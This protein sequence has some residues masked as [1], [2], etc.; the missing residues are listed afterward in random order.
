MNVSQARTGMSPSAGWRA[1][2][3][4]LGVLVLYPLSLEPANALAARG[5]LDSQASWTGALN[6]GVFLAVSR[7]QWPRGWSGGPSAATGTL[8]GVRVPDCRGR[9]R[10]REEP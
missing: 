7:R 9:P 4:V 1:L 6:C 10:I 3:F 8:G 2:L 5:L